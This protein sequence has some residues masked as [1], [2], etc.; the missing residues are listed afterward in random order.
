MSLND[1]NESDETKSLN[2]S[3]EGC[4]KQYTLNQKRGYVKMVNEKGV[5]QTSFETGIH[6]SN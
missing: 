3:K 6:A 2:D 1:D 4:L 5:T